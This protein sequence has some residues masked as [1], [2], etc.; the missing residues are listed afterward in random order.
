MREILEPIVF[1]FKSVEICAICEKPFI[2]CFREICA[3]CETIFAAVI[4]TQ[5]GLLKVELATFRL[6]RRR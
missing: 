1:A 6:R 5:K 4:R 3:I 2:G